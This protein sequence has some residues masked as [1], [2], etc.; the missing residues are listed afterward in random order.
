MYLY[1]QW[2]RFQRVQCV[3]CRP[4]VYLCQTLGTPHKHKT[5]S[6]INHHSMLPH[7]YASYV[8]WGATYC[9]FWALSCVFVGVPFHSG[10]WPCETIPVWFHKSLLHASPPACIIC[11][12]G[13]HLSVSIGVPSHSGGWPCETI[14]VWFHKPL[15]HASPPACII[16]VLESHLSWN[17]RPCWCISVYASSWGRVTMWNHSY[18]VHKSP[19]HVTW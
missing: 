3:K 12:L 6:L 19:F 14:P 2:V 10:G 15:L 7:L 4:V 17:L 13:S 5:T 8:C 1:P 18:S 9:E 16:C 11:V